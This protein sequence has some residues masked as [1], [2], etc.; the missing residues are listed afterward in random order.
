MWSNHGEEFFSLFLFLVVNVVV[1]TAGYLVPQRTPAA[2][3]GRI[4]SVKELV[5]VD[6]RNIDCQ[7]KQGDSYG[8][9]LVW[10]F[11]IVDGNHRHPL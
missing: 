1:G 11:F 3:M 10:M 4:R 8:T 9:I 7:G 5:G 6:S 2:W